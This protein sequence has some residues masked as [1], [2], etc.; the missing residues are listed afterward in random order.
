MQREVVRYWSHIE[1]NHNLMGT[2]L[3][4]KWEAAMGVVGGGG[5]RD[6]KD[7]STVSSGKAETTENQPGQGE[8]GG[9]QNVS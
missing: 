6:V 7:D 4:N 2:G 5:E 9:S 8:S 1:M 3:R